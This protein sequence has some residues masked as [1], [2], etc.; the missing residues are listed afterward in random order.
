MS[1]QQ[2]QEQIENDVNAKLDAQAQERAAIFDRI[3]QNATND[4]A[5][6]QVKDAR[7]AARASWRAYYQ[8]EDNAGAVMGWIADATTGLLVDANELAERIEQE[9]EP[10]DDSF[11]DPKS[12]AT[13]QEQ[14]AKHCHQSMWNMGRN[15]ATKQFDE[16]D[17]HDKE[18]TA[19]EFF[20][21][22]GCGPTVATGTK[23]IT[24]ESANVAAS[25]MGW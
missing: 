6:Q 10:F 17:K 25:L 19:R 13:R 20:E 11:F 22:H 24:I 18:N 23:S 12:K 14:I 16:P 15:L 5:E 21:K 2:T 1:D 3:R 4:R 7:S 9:V 8:D